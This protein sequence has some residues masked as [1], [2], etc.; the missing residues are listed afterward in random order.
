MVDVVVTGTGGPVVVSASAAARRDLSNVSDEVFAEKAA[1]AG[2]GV[3]LWPTSVRA[4]GSTNDRAAWTAFLADAANTTRDLPAGTTRIVLGSGQALSLPAGLTL[5]GQGAGKTILRLETT[6]NGQS[7]LLQTGVGV[8]FEDLTLHLVPASGTTGVLIDWRLDELSFH[9]CT[10]SGQT[11]LAGDGVNFTRSAQGIKF[12]ETG[13]QAGL[14]VTECDLTGFKFPFLKSNAAT[15]AQS[16]IRIAGCHAYANWSEDI[17]INSPAG[18]L[19]DVLIDG[20]TV[21]S[22]L[23]VPG[24]ARLGIAIATGSNC[25]I[26]HNTINGDFQD[27][28]HIEEAID[29]LLIQGNSGTVSGNGIFVLENNIGGAHHTPKRALICDNTFKYTGL[30]T[31]H[32][33]L[34]VVWSAITSSL[35]KS[36]IRGNLLEGFPVGMEDGVTPEAYVERSGN[37]AVNCTTGFRL[38]YGGR[39]FRDNTSVSCS[40]GLLGERA[41]S[42]RHTFVD[43]ATSVSKSASGSPVVTYDPT[44]VYRGV[45]P[46]A[47]GVVAG[48]M[49]RLF[50]SD[51]ADFTEARAVIRQ[52]GS[53]VDVAE[54]RF[55][56]V[57]WDGTTLNVTSAFNYIAGSVNVGLQNP[58]GILSP[59]TSDTDNSGALATVEVELRGCYI[60]G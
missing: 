37:Q 51:R 26:V 40:V 60:R 24:A 32:I 53:S 18:L 42:L 15:G 31:T 56:E 49:M 25:K 13:S 21:D 16:R 9:R 52:Q 14:S 34:Q 19:D 43:C 7:A 33:G 45:I 2:I 8:R 39:S 48:A 10:L 6:T 47:G 11:T 41:T 55:S 54:R 20:N 30:G 28:I 46:T 17:S 35:D 50:G 29:G 3:A 44:F 22:P 4:D 38:V 59:V 1:Q 23:R 57:S 27:A 58:G 5:R 36:V 12:R